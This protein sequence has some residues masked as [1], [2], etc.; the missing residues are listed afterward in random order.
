MPEI[1]IVHPGGVHLDEIIAAG[2]I[3]RERG[4]LPVE[5]REPTNAELADPEVWVVDVGR[6]HE[7]DL[8]NFDHHQFGEDAKP[9]SAMSLV[10]RYLGLHDLL[11]RRPWYRAQVTVDVQ[12]PSALAKEQGIGDRIP[13]TLTSPIDVGIRHLWAEGGAGRVDPAIVNMASRIASAIVAE[14]EA[15]EALSDCQQLSVVRRIGNAPI[16]F[17]DTEVSNAVS[18][19]IKADWEEETGD[20]IAASVSHDT[21]EPFG[22]ALYRFDDD[23]RIDFSKLHGDPRFGFVSEVGFIAKTR[24]RVGLDEVEAMIRYSLTGQART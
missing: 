18:N 13:P 12:G 10:A 23:P 22:W 21:R 7:P 20:V 17:H 6:R 1:I 8:R 3:C 5:R 15:L 14:A 11:S 16:L 2:L 24:E 19:Q 4:D 9:E